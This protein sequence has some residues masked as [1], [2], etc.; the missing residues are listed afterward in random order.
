MQ[1]INNYIEK[2]FKD[3]AKSE[4][5]SLDYYDYEYW[6]YIFDNKSIAIGLSCKYSRILSR[7]EYR[8]KNNI[9]KNFGLDMVSLKEYDEYCGY[10]PNFGVCH[11]EITFKNGKSKRVWVSHIRDCDSI[12]LSCENLKSSFTIMLEVAQKKGII[13][14]TNEDSYYNE[15]LKKVSWEDFKKLWMEYYNESKFK[16][17]DIETS[18]NIKILG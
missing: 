11:T 13:N 16:N 5:R 10:D 4:G 12:G 9:K 2:C 6:Y 17:L 18:E 3:A 14:S 8:L 15:F 7:V 1:K